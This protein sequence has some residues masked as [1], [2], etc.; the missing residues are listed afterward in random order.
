M[1][2][3]EQEGCRLLAEVFVARGFPV[4]R[5]IPFDENGVSFDIDGWNAEHRVGF[6]YRTSEAGDKDDL[7]LDELALLAE[8]MEAG[9]LFIFVIDDTSI[10]AKD[11]L[12]L[13]ANAFLDEVERRRGGNKAGARR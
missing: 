12:R 7:S 1:L 4:V 3:A 2:V 9:E 8:R 6:E 5:D 10:E 13:Y 11:D